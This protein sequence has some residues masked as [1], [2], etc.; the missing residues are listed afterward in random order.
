MK[1]VGM[2]KIAASSLVLVTAIAPVNASQYGNEASAP[3]KVA[4]EAAQQAAKFM[5]KHKFANAVE[6]AEIAVAAMPRV[7]EYRALL[8]QAYLSAGR[9]VSA[10]TMLGEAASLDPA[11]VRAGL[12]LALAQ[13]ANAHNDRALATLDTYR[14]RLAAADFGLAAALAGD[15][16][17]AT[18]VLEAAVRAPESDA[19]TRQNLALAYALSNRWREA[20]IMASQDLAGDV[21]YA[22]MTEWAA[23]SNPS[24]ASQQVATL[25]RVTP[26]FDPG[27]P[28]QLALVPG[29]D[30]QVAMAIPARLPE[31]AA[32]ASFSAE[33]APVFEVS[34]PT[35]KSAPVAL[36]F[37]EPAPVQPAPV[38]VAD[39]S[40][41]SSTLKMIA[42]VIWGDSRPVVQAVPASYSRPVPL[43]RSAA[44]PVKQ[45]VVPAE[46]S[47]AAQSARPF[48][49][50]ES[51]NFVVQLGAFGNEARAQIAWRGAV[52]HIHE[53]ANY[54]AS[55]A[56]VQVKD[57]SLF[58][59]SVAGFTTR[60]AASQLCLR[61]KAAGGDCFVRTVAGDTPLQWASIPGGTKLASRN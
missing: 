33:R 40:P 12:N 29:S 1:T 32:V 7:A 53:L 44:R 20:R 25:L 50:V 2:L 59:L 61:I 15:L 11:N 45:V 27:Q 17:G 35:P 22:R 9:F 54:G 19:K 26:I 49:P 21:L 39:A 23:M 13:T 41:V 24:T 31:P 56:R 28:Q 48:R 51:G 37:V 55:S 10:E 3:E 36:A 18:R 60:A 16:E 57:A 30:Q 42:G 47:M 8:G 6:K 58:R 14:D 43:I 34:D 4:A 46:N 5:D 38:E 52:G